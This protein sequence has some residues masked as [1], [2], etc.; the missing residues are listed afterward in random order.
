MEYLK[1]IGKKLAPY[2]VGLSILSGVA[3]T[4]YAD[5]PAEKIIK[6]A[7]RGPILST[8]DLVIATPCKAIE[9]HGLGGKALV[10]GTLGAVSNSGSRLSAATLDATVCSLDETPLYNRNGEVIELGQDSALKS[11]VINA[12]ADPF[13]AD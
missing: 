7:W 9:K 6:W 10:E 2:V 12:V 8:V 3:T 4:A 5:S 11:N 1:N 13:K